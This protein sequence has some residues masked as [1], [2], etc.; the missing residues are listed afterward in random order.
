MQYLA[1]EPVRHSEVIENNIREFPPR[2]NIYRVFLCR[3]NTFIHKLILIVLSSPTLDTHNKL[4]LSPAFYRLA[5]HWSQPSP[6]KLPGT[7]QTVPLQCQPIISPHI[8]IC[9]YPQDKE[10]KK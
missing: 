9:T 1:E 6:W 10:E 5:L 3:V 8:Q 7:K 4:T 2:I